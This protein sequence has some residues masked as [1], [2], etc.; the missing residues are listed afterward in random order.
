[1]SGSTDH[2]LPKW[3]R[4][5]DVRCA[6]LAN[7]LSCSDVGPTPQPPGVPIPREKA[8]QFQPETWAIHG[9]STLTNDASS[10]AKRFFAAGGLGILVGDGTLIHSAPENIIET[11]YEWAAI[12]ALKLTADYQFIVNPAYNT[13]RGPVSVFGICAHIQF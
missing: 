5:G 6:V 12:G 1:M 2:V 4:A 13:D 10:A 8:E 11:Y 9:Q 7:A 3:G